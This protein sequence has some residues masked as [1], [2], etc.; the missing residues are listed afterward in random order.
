ML[1]FRSVSKFQMTHPKTTTEF[2]KL[3]FIFQSLKVSKYMATNNQS[4][5]PRNCSSSRQHKNS[6]LLKVTAE[7]YEFQ[8]PIW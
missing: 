2:L 5:I 4:Q 8:V 1:I 6:I 3:G 7:D